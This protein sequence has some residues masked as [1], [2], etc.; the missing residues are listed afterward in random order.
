MNGCTRKSVISISRAPMETIAAAISSGVVTCGPP[1]FEHQ[2]YCNTKLLQPF[3]GGAGV[4]E[5]SPYAAHWNATLA[6]DPSI[7]RYS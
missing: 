3:V 5:L 4:S 2:V 7:E 1:N 6:P